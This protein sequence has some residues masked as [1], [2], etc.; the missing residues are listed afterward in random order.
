MAAPSEGT[1]A[2]RAD[3]VRSLERG[4]A[5]LTAFEGHER[6]SASDVA[7]KTGLTRAAVRR[8]LLTLTD[9]GYVNFDGRMFRLAP[10]ILE[11]PSA[12]L[13]ALA[14]PEIA[15]P[16]LRALVADVR[17]SASLAVLDGEDVVY[18]EQVVGH[19]VLAVPVVIG[20]RDSAAATSLGRVLLAHKP[21]E[22][23]DAFLR[24]VRL[25][26]FTDRTIVDPKRLASELD[27]VR[28]QGWALV[29]EEL[30][31]G[32][33]AIAA[34]I[35]D[36]SGGVVAAANVALHA[37]RWQIAEIKSELLPRLLQMTDAITLAVGRLADG[38]GAGDGMPAAAAVARGSDFVQSLERGLATICAFSGSTVPL[39]LSQVAVRA[40]LARAAARRFLLTLT[41]LGY[42]ATDGRAFWLTAKVLEIGRGY[43]ERVTL[44]D[45]AQPYLRTLAERTDESASLAVL[46]GVEIVYLANESTPRILSVVVPVGGRDPAWVTSLGR[47]L[48]A[49][50]DDDVLEE[51][52][53]GV[54][55]TRFTDNTVRHVAA[56]RAELERA[57]S[58]GWSLVDEEFEEGLRAVAVPVR[59]HTGRTVAA[60]N[61]S[62]NS[63]RWTLE[64]MRSQLVPELLTAADAIERQLARARI[65]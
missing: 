1:R 45:V 36:A 10:R 50:L 55:T 5:V 59:D 63:R 40:G 51:R 49:G 21:D 7:A 46:D 2:P 15:L 30:E 12:Y 29:D 58:L 3:F 34:P 6:L 43:L 26:R 28:R 52:L 65:A 53:G 22:W 19:R 17:E 41:D 32:L 25:E 8:F 61:F 11:L 38:D 23:I 48:L 24:N 54:T 44:A 14:L 42:V 37:S 62:V 16:H 20:G 47:V 33:R 56:L 57:R 31:D 64:K 4:L 9:L 35:R 27:R 13:R 60:I 39:T 18:V